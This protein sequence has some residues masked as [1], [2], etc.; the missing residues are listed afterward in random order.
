MAAELEQ[1]TFAQEVQKD[2][3]VFNLS[4]IPDAELDP[5][6]NTFNIDKYN[7][8]IEQL[9]KNMIDFVDKLA[10][11]TNREPSE[12][13]F[14][15]FIV[16]LDG[17]QKLVESS[18][19]YPI[20]QLQ[21]M[22]QHMER[23]A[24]N[25]KKDAE[26]LGKIRPYLL[27]EIQ[28]PEYSGKTLEELLT[29]SEAWSDI[30][31]SVIR[32]AEG[33]KADNG[34]EETAKL[35]PLL[36]S[37]TPTSHIMPNNSL[38]N[39]LQQ[40]PAINTGAFDMVV[41]NATKKRK[42]ITSYT[43]INYESNDTGITIAN[44]KLS[45]YER[46]VSDA[47]IS[48]WEQAKKDGVPPVFST[49]MIYRAMPGSGDKASAQQRGAITRTIEK[50]RNLHIYIDAT[51][52][53]KKR[54]LIG[55]KGKFTIDDNYLSAKKF[56]YIKAK[57][58]G[59]TIGSAYMIQSEP[60]VLMYARMT[61]QIITIPAKYIAIKKI[62]NDI[63]S[64]EAITMNTERQAMSGYLIRQIGWMKYDKSNKV[65]NP[66]SDIILFDT[67]FKETGTYTESRTQANRNRDFIY[68]VLDYEKAAGYIAGYE[69]QLRGRSITGVKIKLQNTQ[70]TQE[71]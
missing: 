66:R 58:G 38:M 30:V 53:M 71:V 15:D 21:S 17:L 10:Q 55:K 20:G 9:K 2:T 39:T 43:I 19:A 36:Q 57:N 62:K 27:K 44:N 31:W 59:Q 60:I 61:K 12:K 1:E 24:D 54:G 34:I 40:K 23:I 65:S 69:K 26:T 32:S 25:L 3:Y 50:L 63:I 8:H 4:D 6:S 29:D 42:E 51:E 18:S 37:I 7:A 16:T 52:E 28:R 14:A 45:E 56:E 49:D 48:L 67:L 70:E 47:V 13:V 64:G 68:S 11:K 33:A 22:K 46:Q 41:S 5:I 35:L